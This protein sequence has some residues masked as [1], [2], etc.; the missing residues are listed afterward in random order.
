MDYRAIDKVAVIS[1]TTELRI[2]DYIRKIRNANKKAYANALLNCRYYRTNSQKIDEKI[3]GLSCMGA[4]A[5]RMSFDEIVEQV[6]EEYKF[7]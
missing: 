5:V 3:F 2:K 1:A 4:Q 7:C 6:K